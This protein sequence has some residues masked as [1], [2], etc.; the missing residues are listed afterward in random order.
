LIKKEARILG[1]AAPKGRQKQIP[2]IGI[3][4]RGN[5]WLDAII[6]CQSIPNG[7]EHLQDLVKA[8]VRS[9]QYPQIH[10]VILSRE[11]LAPGLQIDISDFSRRINL[12]V[13][14]ITERTACRKIASQSTKEVRQV[15]HL[16]FKVSGKVANVK[17][18]GLNREEAQ[19]IFQVACAN[20][21]RIPEAVRVAEI[22][23][24]QSRQLSFS[25]T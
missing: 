19:E 23:A 16:S 15:E 14:C 3:V 1:L 22:I 5:L 4:Y 18:V 7:P 8:I 24:N 13:I 25:T 17:I 20:D 2:V 9:K 11:D 10:A 6:V 21:Q 12:P